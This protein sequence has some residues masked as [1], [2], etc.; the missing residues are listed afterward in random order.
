M[1]NDLWQRFYED[2]LERGWS[3]S[4]AIA[5]AQEKMADLE[6]RAMVTEDMPDGAALAVAKDMGLEPEDIP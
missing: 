3:E 1:D 6:A 5:Y 4:M 2:A